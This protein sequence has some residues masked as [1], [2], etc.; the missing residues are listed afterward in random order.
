M[1]ETGVG[2]EPQLHAPADLVL[3]RIARGI[4]DFLDALR[5]S[6]V[7][8]ACN[9]LISLVGLGPGLTPSGDDIVSGIVA[10][11]FWQSRLGTISEETTREISASI[12]AA[13]SRTNLISARL[14]HHACAGVL[15]AP[16]MDLGAVLLS[17]DPHGVAGPLSRL[18]SIGSTTGLDLATGLLIGC[19]ATLPA[20]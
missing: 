17:G 12:R 19:V 16:A 8:T 20:T 2:S 7:A 3:A 13:A 6:E 1:T 9:S 11:F 15:Y 4:V 14:M 18:T 5:S 10:M